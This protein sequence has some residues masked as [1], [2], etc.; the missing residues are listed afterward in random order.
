MNIRPQLPSSPTRPETPPIEMPNYFER[1][2][3]DKPQYNFYYAPN[4]A[5]NNGDWKS[6]F[7]AN[8]QHGIDHATQQLVSS[9][10]TGVISLVAVALFSR[11]AQQA[12][13]S[14]ERSP[15][16]ELD[17]L[18]KIMILSGQAS[19]L[20]TK[21]GIPLAPVLEM[22]VRASEK[23]ANYPIYLQALA[24][25]RKQKAENRA[26]PEVNQTA[27]V[28]EVSKESSSPTQKIIS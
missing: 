11:I 14:L 3:S 9:A 1:Q 28:R 2:N 6:R 4:S 16:E 25:E 10:I 7:S 22:L 18:L 15:N 21:E 26:N 8:I 24:N 23:D 19:Q 17:Q 12:S 20:L 5:P 27:P 13:S